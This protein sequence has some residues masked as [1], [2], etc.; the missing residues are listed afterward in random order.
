[1]SYTEICDKMKKGDGM[2][3][4]EDNAAK[5]PY[6]YAGNFW[7]GYDNEKS[8]VYKVKTLVKGRGLAGAMFW[9]LNMDDYDGTHC[10]DGRYPLINAVKK[11]LGITSGGAPTDDKTP[12]KEQG[13]SPEK[14]QEKSPEKEQEKSPEKEKGKSPESNPSPSK[15]SKDG[16]P[17]DDPYQSCHGVAPYDENPGIDKWCATNCAAGNCPASHCLCESPQ[18]TTTEPPPVD[19]GNKNSDIQAIL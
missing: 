1:M 3:V 7:V 15:G 5:A 4:V 8:L 18:A 12:E 14:E 2:T 9:T 11:E 13:K 6:A 19:N 10:G 16:G 17:S